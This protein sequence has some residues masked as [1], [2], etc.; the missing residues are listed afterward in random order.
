MERARLNEVHRWAYAAIALALFA[1]QTA[2]VPACAQDD[3]AIEAGRITGETFQLIRGLTSRGMPELVAES[4][5]DHPPACRIHVARAFRQAAMMEAVGESRTR[6][7]DESQRE[8]RALIARDPGGGAERSEWA[9]YHF[10]EC[11]V[12]LAD[13]LLNHRLASELNRLE[14][15]SGLAG[16]R[17]ALEAGLA[18]VVELHRRAGLGLARL[19]E[20]WRLTE[21]RFMLLGLTQ[22]L[23]SLGRAQRTGLAWAQVYRAEVTAS[24]D[25][26]R[27]G[28]ANAALAEFDALSQEAGDSDERAAALLGKGIALRALHAWD[29]AGAVLKRVVDAPVAAAVSVRAQYEIGRTLLAAGRWEAA[30]AVL[31]ALA[32]QSGVPADSSGAFYVRLAPILHAW[33]WMEEARAVARSKS[34][35]KAGQAGAEQR[36]ETTKAFESLRDRAIE[37]FERVSRRGPEWEALARVYLDRIVPSAAEPTSLSDASLRVAAEESLSREDFRRAEALLKTLTER[38]LDP[39]Q[40]ASA[41]LNLGV[42]QYRLGRAREALSNVEK[43]VNSPDDAVAARAVEQAYRIAR[44]VALAD[45]RPEDCRALAAAAQRLVKCRPKHELADEA[46]YSAALAFQE[47]GD[48]EEAIAAFEQVPAE[49]EYYARA[50]RGVAGG[51]QHLYD[52][53]MEARSKL[54]APAARAAAEA[55]LAFA[56]TSELGGSADVIQSARLQAARLLKSNLVGAFDEAIAAV[57]PLEPDLD[58]LA[59]RW[60]CLQRLGRF[61]EAS[62]VLGQTLKTPIKSKAGD[63]VTSLFID[64]EDEITRF[65]AAGQREK[66]THLAGEG[67]KLAERLTGLC[68]TQAQYRDQ[69][70]VARFAWARYLARAGHPD[71][72]LEQLDQLMRRSPKRGDYIALAA[73]LCEEQSESMDASSR[74]SHSEKAEAL[75]GRLLEDSALRESNPAL[76]WQARYCWL[77]H[78]MR[79]GRAKDVA[80]GIANDRAWYPDLGGPPWQ[81]RLIELHDEAWRLSET[82][83]P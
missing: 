40:L 5:N 7:L 82:S 32:R 71:E 72:A 51:R 21:E 27:I 37:E 13:L 31:A 83:P 79:R 2:A 20:A 62:D 17:K 69:E 43:A 3:P 44:E 68:M 48:W 39:A 78:Q 47:A 12:E 8:Y 61:K 64:I 19:I 23:R 33:S 38:R 26:A 14:M 57:A 67:V 81:A 42:C 55:W 73:R 53:A 10:A 76:Y 24:D 30:R 77:R 50:L 15:T 52:A 9:E 80:R 60:H 6:L 34:A 29:D 28:W 25:A 35:N 54:A 74:A 65:D 4:V 1:A 46:R 59:L 63:V 66:A 75:W 16:D 45:R 56:R 41:A 70:D 18:E 22:P 58:V 49:S 36:G 11:R